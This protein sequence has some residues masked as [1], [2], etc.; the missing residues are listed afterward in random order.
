MILISKAEIYHIGGDKWAVTDQEFTIELTIRGK[1][2][3]L[4]KKDILNRFEVCKLA[5]QKNRQKSKK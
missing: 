3:D 4:V 2:T 1:V 5:A